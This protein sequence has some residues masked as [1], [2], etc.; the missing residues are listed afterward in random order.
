MFNWYI[1]LLIIFVAL[2]F[3]IC[4]LMLIPRRKKKNLLPSSDKAISLNNLNNKLTSTGF[5]YSGKDDVFYSRKDAWQRDFGYCHLYDEA[6]PLVGMIVDCEPISF[7]Y[8]NKHWL[9]EFR[10]GQYGMATGGEI[11]IYNTTY[12]QIKA[13][14]F[15]GVFYETISD[16]ECIPLE[17]VLKKNKKIL[18]HQS[19]THWWLAGLKLAEFSNTAAL[20]LDAKLVFPNPKMR[21][22]FVAG[23]VSAGYTNREFIVRFHTVIVHFTKPH[24]LQPASRTRI[25]EAIIQQGNENNCELYHNLTTKHDNTF[26]K[27]EFL[28]NSSPELYDKF[29]KSFH[30]KELYHSFELIS[31]IL[32]K[33]II[34]NQPIK[35]DDPLTDS[36]DL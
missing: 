28:I 10:K 33:F 36:F 27:L 16:E 2:L 30:S 17:F 4:V 8:D 35:I 20:S 13:P 23:L 9:I 34:A 32:K 22:A 24:T 6:M 29:L 25:H 19:S 21:D 7:D 15:H 11:G 14:G 18:I 1:F 12:P 3:L 5:S 31:P 26:D